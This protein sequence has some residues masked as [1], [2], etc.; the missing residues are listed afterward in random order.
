[1]NDKNIKWGISDVFQNRGNVNE[2]IINW[3]KKN[4]WTVIHFNK[5]Y[6]FNSCSD[7]KTDEVYICNYQVEKDI[8]EMF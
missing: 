6:S 1:M 3:C 8:F 7:S 2:H 4:N 5:N